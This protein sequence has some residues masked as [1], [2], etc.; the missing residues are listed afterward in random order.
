MTVSQRLR[1]SADVIFR[2]LD[3]EAVLL[4]LGSG[5]YY[6]LNGVATRVWTLVAGGTPVEGVLEALALEF[7]AE[8]PR[9]ATDVEALLADLIDRGLLVEDAAPR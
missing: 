5:R 9:I 3:G 7:D 6:G 8:A 1:P 4:D 2:E